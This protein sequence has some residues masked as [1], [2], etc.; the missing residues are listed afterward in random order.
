[1]KLYYTP[2]AC[3]LADHIAL[4][5]AE[6]PHEL[7]KVDLRTKTIEDGADFRAINPKGYV[8]ALGLDD[9]EVLTENIAILL[10]I[11]DKAGALIPA[12]GIARWRVI[13]TTAFIT[14]ELHKGFKPF[15]N[16]KASEAERDEA[17]A[18]LGD[19][20]RRME[21]QIGDRAFIVGD[22]MTIADAYLFVM[23]MWAGKF[24]L[25][26]PTQLAGYA[27]RLKARPAVQ[28]ALVAEGLA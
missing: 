1:M 27:E 28:R 4:E 6:L 12:D 22:G 10:Y 11:A 14:T 9:G 26:V 18:A 7:V 2:G 17:R 5:E 8:P 3:S 16:P 19:R 15:F 21:A 20:F 25:D 24:A 13:E 23:L